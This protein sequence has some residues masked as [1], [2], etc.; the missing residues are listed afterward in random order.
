[1]STEDSC[2]FQCEDYF[3]LLNRPTKSIVAD[4]ES[5]RCDSFTS[6]VSKEIQ[7]TLSN[8]N[9]TSLFC[10]PK[11]K[12][13]YLQSQHQPDT[14]L[15]YGRKEDEYWKDNRPVS[16]SLSLRK[17][18]FPAHRPTALERTNTRKAL[19]L[20]DSAVLKVGPYFGRSPC[21]RPE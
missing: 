5:K 21:I 19:T 20:V 18:F 11:S 13:C 7:T 16:S 10:N 14:L 4:S 15:W 1:M 8:L 6:K 17:T 2:S 12:W 9:I 3:N